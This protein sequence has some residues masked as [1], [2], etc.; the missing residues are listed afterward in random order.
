LASFGWGLGGFEGKGW[1]S[2]FLCE[3]VCAVCGSGPSGEQEPFLEPLVRELWAT[4]GATGAREEIIIKKMALYVSVYVHCLTE[5][6]VGSARQRN[7]SSSAPSVA[8]A[9]LHV[10]AIRSDYTTPLFMFPLQ[11]SREWFRRDGDVCEKGR[12]LTEDDG[13]IDAALGWLWSGGSRRLCIRR[14]LQ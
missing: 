8:A 7:M 13:S 12:L 4:I 10:S 3:I 2:I 14:G 1:T 9:E 11:C 6:R 5:T